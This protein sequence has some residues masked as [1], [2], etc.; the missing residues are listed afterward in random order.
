MT[1][2][3][4]YKR[5]VAAVGATELEPGTWLDLEEDCVLAFNDFVITEYEPPVRK[6]AAARL[7]KLKVVHT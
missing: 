6:A 4:A 7:K 1:R 2:E 3:E 5:A